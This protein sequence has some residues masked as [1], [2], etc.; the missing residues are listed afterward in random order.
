MKTIF[1]IFIFLVIA[2][3]VIGQITSKAYVFSFS[4]FNPISGTYSSGRG[5]IQNLDSLQINLATDTDFVCGL[6]KS[7]GVYFVSN[8]EIIE[9]DSCY[10][11]GTSE[12]MLFKRQFRQQ[13]RYNFKTQ[14][15]YFLLFSCQ[16]VN[17]TTC[18]IPIDFGYSMC[19]ICFPIQEYCYP[20]NYMFVLKQVYS[21]KKLNKKDRNLLEIKFK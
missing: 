12:T 6:Y 13:K 21:C 1:S 20:L 7:G 17:I 14:A 15:N 9:I 16:E 5:I 19:T 3:D 18:K 10:S 2:F 8:Y 11:I 4:V